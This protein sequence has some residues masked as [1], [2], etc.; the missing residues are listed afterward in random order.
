MFLSTKLPKK[1]FKNSF[2]KGNCGCRRCRVEKPAI[3]S[4]F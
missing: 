2:K 1:G 3:L 4:L